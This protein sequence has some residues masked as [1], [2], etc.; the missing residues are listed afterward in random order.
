MND[1]DRKGKSANL[2]QVNE[3]ESEMAPSEMP[4]NRSENQQAN[5]G[6]SM[7]Q[8]YRND[9]EDGHTSLPRKDG[10]N[11]IFEHRDSLF[12]I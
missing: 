9:V 5:K 8:F 4:E 3:T 6:V 10:H 2:F 11:V 1:G 7:E 12:L